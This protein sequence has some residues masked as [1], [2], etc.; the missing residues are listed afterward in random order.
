[1]FMN[2]GLMKYWIVLGVPRYKICCPLLPILVYY[3]GLVNFVQWKNL[4]YARPDDQTSI[5]V[6]L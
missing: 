1:M 6:E 2:N 3:I 5:V 4:F